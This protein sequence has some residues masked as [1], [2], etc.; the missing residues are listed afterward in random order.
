MMKVFIEREK[1]WVDVQA[2]SMRDIVK[3]LKLNPTTVLL[4]KNKKVVSED[5][6]VTET[7]EVKILS[8][9]SGG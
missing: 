8:V 2:A 5:A 4:V 9:I 3:A 1:K 7:D 6:L